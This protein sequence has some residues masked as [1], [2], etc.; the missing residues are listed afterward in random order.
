MRGR[1]SGHTVRTA[2][3]QAVI[4]H[5]RPWLTKADHEA[6]DASLDSVMVADGDLSRKLEAAA[7]KYLGQAGGVATPDG[8]TALF[9]ALRAL[10]VGPSDDVVIPTYVCEAVAQAVR[11]TGATPVLCDVGDDWCVNADTVRLAL[12][13]RTRAVV[14]VHTFGIVAEVRPIAELGLPVIEDLAQAFGASSQDGPAGAFGDLSI[15]SFHATKCLTT[16][17]GGMAFTRDQ[18]MLARL[19]ALKRSAHR[20]PLSNLQAALGLSQLRRYGEFLSRRA[21]IA[22]RYCR[23]IPDRLLPTKAVLER[24]IHFRFPVRVEG[25]VESLMAAFESRDVLAKRGV[26]ALLHEEAGTFAGAESAFEHTLSLPIHPS[27]SAEEVGRVV[28]AA[29]EVLS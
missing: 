29:Q 26:D 18:R 13:K 28:E 16:G 17:E 14:V 24:T 21:R 1:L 11:W 6:L 15:A 23:A 19:R 4:P 2:G 3:R 22:E 20:L 10:N 5:S 9:L 25:D 12:T 27:M 7:A 8:T